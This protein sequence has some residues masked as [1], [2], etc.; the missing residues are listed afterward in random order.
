MLLAVLSALLVTLLVPL[1]AFPPGLALTRRATQGLLPS[2][3]V[4][5]AAAFGFGLLG[6]AFFT[7]G[8][9]SF[10]RTTLGAVVLAGGAGWFSA[11]LRRDL[12]QILQ[13]IER[14]RWPWVAAFGASL[15]FLLLSGLAE[16]VGTMGHDGI[17]YHLQGPRIWLREGRIVPMPDFSLTAFPVSVEAIFGALMAFSNHR[18]PCAIG[19]VFV[20]LLLVQT[21]G[22]ARWTG[23]SPG[24]SLTAAAVV[25]TMPV[26]VVQSTTAFVDVPYAVYALSAVRVALLRTTPAGVIVGGAFIGFAMGTKYSGL[27]LAFGTV[28]LALVA[29]LRR[30]DRTELRALAGAVCIG[31]LFALPFYLRNYLVLGSPIYPPP[32]A[33]YDYLEVRYFPRA[34]AVAMEAYVY[35]R[36]YGFGHGPLDLLLVPWRFSMSP[37][38]F[39]GA[40]GIGIVP[41]ALA[42]IGWFVA[43][44]RAGMAELT[45]WALFVGLVWFVT[46]QEARFAQVLFVLGAVLGALGASWLA[47]RSRLGKALSLLVTGVSIVYGAVTVVKATGPASLGPAALSALSPSRAEK[48]RDEIPFRRAFEALNAAKDVG[49]VLIVDPKAPPYYLEHPHTKIVGMYGE[50]PFD[51]PVT[52]TRLAEVGVTHVFETDKHPAPPWLL[53]HL[54]LLFA[55]DG[56]RVSRIRSDGDAGSRPVTTHHVDHPPSPSQGAARTP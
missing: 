32:V 4:A 47:S 38:T 50:T 10:T 53:P 9:A 19:A 39:H 41:L 7:V 51:G 44:K 30:K 36:G 15:G 52:L 45:A 42:P 16:P 54:E 14:P 12:A 1:L 49:R 48:R 22:L 11:R 46:Q 31:S 6:V 56:A 3:R 21:H 8:L 20:A 23:A 13:A 35:E 34:A 25:V 27:P 5:I 18:A 55:A 37:G 28:G 43:R 29:A 2:E 40:G 24:W 26:I 33:L 17:S